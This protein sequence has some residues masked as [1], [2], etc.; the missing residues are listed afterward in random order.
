MA[1]PERT[2]LASVAVMCLTS[3][4]VAGDIEP[5]KLSP[6]DAVEIGIA[7]IADRTQ[8]AV[9]QMDG[10]IALP[11]VGMVMVAGLTGSELQTRM[12]TLL[13]TKIF[14][15]R[16]PDG[17]EQMVVIKP[18]DVT[19]TIADYRPIYVMGDVLTPGQ[20]AYRPL[21]TVR[22]ALAV[23]GGF[24]LL[25]SR[26]GQTGPDPVDLRRDYETLWGDYTKDYFHAARL[27]AELQDQADFDTQIPQGSP[28]SPSIGAA[29]AQAEGD[30]LKIA[31]SDFQQ[32]QAFLEKGEK[33]TADQIEVLQKREQVEAEGVKADQEDLARVTK[34][35]ESGNLTNNRLA[36]V[37]R[38]LLLS[39]SGALQT[40]VELMRARRQQEDYVR[41]HERNENQ[42]KIGLLIDLKDT[43]ARLADVTTKLHAASEKLQ[44][45]GASAQPLPIAGETIRAQ[46]TIVRKMSEEWR[47]LAAGEDTI[48][49]P[50]DT[51]EARFSTDLQSAAVQ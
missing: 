9:V 20:Q 10:N 24:S 21:M 13:P 30:G 47:K 31:L 34:V 37:R 22:Q 11:E 27:R 33:D 45:T 29:I 26:A 14:H 38:A 40:S 41:Q 28:L 19:A 17:R 8:R 35:F 2:A 43:N 49:M 12:Q 15:V 39:S 50:G 6:G 16:L 51:V 46:V 4:A 1:F 42:R 23:A 48:V 44:P 18:D 32:E 5:Y 7:S 3:M 25:R 36:D